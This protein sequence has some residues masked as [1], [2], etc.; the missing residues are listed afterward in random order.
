[1]AKRCTR[2]GR[3]ARAASDMMTIGLFAPVVM[4]HRLSMLAEDAWRPTAAGRRESARMVAEKPVAAIE[5]AA[6]LQR[7]VARTGFEMGRAMLTASLAPLAVASA[8]T[9]VLGAGARPVSRRV[10]ANAVRL[11]R[12]SVRRGG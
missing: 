3:E 11:A 12:G 8:M 10:R 7:E 1:M 2:L 6:A 4:A 5:A 9:G